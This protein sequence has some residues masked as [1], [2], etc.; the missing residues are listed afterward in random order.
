MSAHTTPSTRIST[1]DRTHLKRRRHNEDH[2]LIEPQTD[3]TGYYGF[4]ATTSESDPVIGRINDD[5]F[6]S[7]DNW[8]AWN[9]GQ[10]VYYANTLMVKK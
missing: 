7:F 8:T 1:I 9:G 10:L 5:G 2:I 4:S 3:R 6:I